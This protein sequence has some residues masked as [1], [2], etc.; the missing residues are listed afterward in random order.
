M[1][2][3]YARIIPYVWS[4]YDL[5]GTKGVLSFGRSCD[6]DI[7]CAL[8][9]AFC[10][11]EMRKPKCAWM[12]CKHMVSRVMGITVI[13]WVPV[14]TGAPVLSLPSRRSC[15]LQNIIVPPVLVPSC[16]HLR[17]T[18]IFVYS[19][20]CAD[21]LWQSCGDNLQVWQHHL[22]AQWDMEDVWP[23]SNTDKNDSYLP[24][25]SISLHGSKGEEVTQQ[26]LSGCA[27]I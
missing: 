2:V 23:Q 20:I 19:L 26:E 25:G 4:I 17:S 6:T 18:N 16:K 3:R 11:F 14:L 8:L 21:N 13:G 7:G 24:R 9:D 12:F 1:V 15:G 27:G 5:H 10:P 22:L